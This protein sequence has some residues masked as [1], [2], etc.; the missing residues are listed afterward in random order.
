MSEHDDPRPVAPEAPLPGDCCD[1]GCD[2][3]VYDLHNE[4][5]ARYRQQLAAW[6]ARHPD[7]AS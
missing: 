5:V 1:S 6:C 4:E 7:Q 3:C 2:R